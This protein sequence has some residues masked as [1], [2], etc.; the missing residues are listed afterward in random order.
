M[1]YNVNTYIRN[2]K[3]AGIYFSVG[4]PV[5]KNNRIV[6]TVFPCNRWLWGDGGR[7]SEVRHHKSEVGYRE[8][9]IL[10]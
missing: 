3:N 7:R 2:T 10:H 5:K 9:Y 8:R 1:M 4:V 6:Q